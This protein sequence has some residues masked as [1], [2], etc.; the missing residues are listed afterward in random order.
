[1][2]NKPSQHPVPKGFSDVEDFTMSDTWRI[3]RIM[4]EFVEAFETMSQ[5]GP[6]VTVFGSARVQPDSPVYKEAEKMGRLLAE[7]GYGVITGGGDGIMGGVNKGAYEAGG[8]SIG[9]NIELLHE[10]VPNQYQTH[11]LFFRYFFIRKVC[12]LKYTLG[13]I[14][15]PGGYGT[16][17]EFLESITLVQTGKI[18][19][20]PIIVVG[21]DFWQDLF[22]WFHHGLLESGAIDEADL[23]LYKVVPD[24]DA[25][26]KY[27]L[28]C[29]R[30]GVQTTVKE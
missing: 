30:Y 22:T 8:N 4:A 2:K 15:F 26:I 25:A 24:A 23:E 13:V 14:V 28:E 7:N 10:Q 21:G 20:I 12:F 9:L 5:Q 29:H 6:L 3:F 1:M 16:L 18:N 11:S 27:L 17:D 19:R